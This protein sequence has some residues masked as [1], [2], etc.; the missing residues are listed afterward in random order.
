MKTTESDT[1]IIHGINAVASV[2]RSGADRV[3]TVYILENL[4]TKRLGRLSAALESSQA[5]VV[6][7]DEAR[8]E[9]LVG[10]A[11]HQGVAALVRDSAR[12]TEA[13]ARPY[14][15]ELQ[16]PVLLVLDSVQDPRNFGACLRTANAAG[17]DLVVT[18]RNRNVGF[19]PAV[20]KVAAGAAE[21]Q[22]TA[23]VSN[24]ARF[25]DFLKE[26]GIWIV[27][28]DAAATT[29]LFEA[30]LSGPV[31]LV[32]GSEGSGLR[33]LTRERCDL[34][35]SLPMNGAVDSLNVSVAAGICLYECRRQ[36]G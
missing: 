10:T 16:Q 8:L 21:A 30:D 5:A 3:A 31:A 24:L 22:A 18:A 20:S 15:Q 7:C 12:M 14:I 11:K 27:G 26:Q 2:L 13:E 34:L 17:A 29:S 6:R 35:V 1:R 33:R 23:V 28:A 9:A 19:T 4:G 25:L 32:L 36:R